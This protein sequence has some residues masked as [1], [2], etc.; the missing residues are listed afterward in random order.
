MPAPTVFDSSGHHTRFYRI[1]HDIADSTVEFFLFTEH[2]AFIPATID[3]AAPVVA[4]VVVDGVVPV[5]IPEQPGKR[6]F[7]YTDEE[8]VMVVHEHIVQKRGSMDFHRDGKDCQE[9]VLVTRVLINVVAVVSPLDDMVDTP[10]NVVSPSAS[11]AIRGL[12]PDAICHPSD[13]RL[14]RRPPWL[15]GFP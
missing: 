8:V 13:I 9:L 1:L 11:H 4:L 14:G 2:I 12:P 15:R 5:Q 10:G 3:G 6:L 7:P